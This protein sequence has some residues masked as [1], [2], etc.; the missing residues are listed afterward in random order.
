MG[1]HHQRRRLDVCDVVRDRDTLRREGAQDGGVVD[2]IAEDR[3]RA[4]ISLLERERDG[5]ANAEAHAQ[6]GGSKDLHIAGF[7]FTQS[8]L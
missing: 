8:P 5:I 7:D 6:A 1:R 4:G 2:E 3:E